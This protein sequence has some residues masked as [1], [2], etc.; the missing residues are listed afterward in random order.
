MWIAGTEGKQMGKIGFY[1]V[2]VLGEGYRY[3]RYRGKEDVKMS[4]RSVW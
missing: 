1:G 4:R 3:G 2:I